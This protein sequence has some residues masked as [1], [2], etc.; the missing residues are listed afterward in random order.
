M[1]S[2]HNNSF[3]KY[4]TRTQFEDRFS[5]DW[6]DM[7]YPYVQHSPDINSLRPVVCYWYNFDNLRNMKNRQ[8]TV[9]TYSWLQLLHSVYNGISVYSS[10]I[11][12]LH[13]LTLMM[14]KTRNI[15]NNSRFCKLFIIL[16]MIHFWLFSD[17]E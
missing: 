1:V 14:E 16:N 7:V 10:I 8:I 13:S 17:I 4:H 11:P 9:F 2:E 5:G 12:A 6:L 15:A 3:G